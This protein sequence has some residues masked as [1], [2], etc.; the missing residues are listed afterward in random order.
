M[1]KQLT[2]RWV[3]SAVLLAALTIAAYWAGLAG[4]FLF[5]DFNNLSSIGATGTVNNLDTFWRY[6][7]SGV[8]DPTGRPLTL[9]TFLLDARDWPADPLPFKRTNLL[10]QLLN[11]AL[12]FALLAKL[13]DLLTIERRRCITA[14][15]LGA[16]LWL[17]HPLFVS[18][19][20]YIVQ[21]EA[22]LP[23]TCVLAGLLVW[24]HGRQRLATCNLKSGFILSAIGL[25]GFTT[26]ATLAKAN[27]AL[28]PIFAVLIEYI[29]LRPI[30]SI[31]TPRARSIYR[32]A[33]WPLAILPTIGICAWLL[34]AGIVGTIT[35][36]TGIRPW[37]IGQRLLTEPRVL[38]D[39]LGLLW[40]P[41]SFS[42][43]LFN[44]Q[45]VASVS[46]WQP[47]TTLPA[48]IAIAAL[49]IGA[50]LVRRRY[51]TLALAVLFYF[52]GQLMESTSL[53]L[54]LYFEHRN[55]LPAML[56]FW[57]LGLWLADTR[58]LRAIKWLLMIVLPL[59]LAVMTFAR[60]ELWGNVHNQALVWAQI[61]PHSAR[62]QANA[63]Q[64]EMQSGQPRNALRRLQPMLAA[65]PDQVQIA[66]NLI[67][68]RCMLGGVL[69]GDIAAARQAM[70]TTTNPGVLF[71][72][73]FDR[74]LPAVTS[75]QCPGLSLADLRGLIEAGLH[76]PK[77]SAAGPQQDLTYLLG[78]IALANH[79]A[80]TALSDFTRA[81]DLQVRPAMALQGAATL[82]AA[83]HPVQGL[84]LLDHYETVKQHTMP[85]GLGMPT[86]H[87]WVLTEQNYWPDELAHLR[88]QLRLDATAANI[89]TV[90]TT[91]DDDP[92]H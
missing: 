36:E 12:L 65:Q 18:T 4:G 85:P 16:A 84:R 48:M 55:Y 19:T 25:G 72:S 66:F 86:I 30:H 37:T 89:N 64:I 44:D 8:A 39:Y 3:L 10:L 32:Y 1:Y 67:G 70:R 14:A 35:D 83:G 47:L 2:I 20:L 63:A 27:G 80:D 62:A 75:N 22:M 57:P 17:L 11:S 73:W 76:N 43:G 54:E 31:P 15:L 68:A 92:A 29:V 60:A 7:T 81:L 23:A 51:P 61:N 33:F 52:A 90:R 59:G 78:R 50:W 82:G 45:Y 38:I 74:T 9:L 21:R 49:I 88:H 40:L 87:A 6:L 71:A 26:L 41:R 56:M 58:Q 53:G 91:G 77:L 42:G 28:L 46:L 13:G 79:D 69:P 5:D 24:L 34:R